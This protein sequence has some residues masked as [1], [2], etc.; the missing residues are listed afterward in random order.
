[1]YES[2]FDGDGGDFVVEVEGDEDEEDL[3]RGYPGNLIVKS[4]NDKTGLEETW[5][6]RAIPCTF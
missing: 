3:G 2:G 1:V 4:N 5:T 6:K